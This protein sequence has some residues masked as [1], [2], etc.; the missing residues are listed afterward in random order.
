MCANTSRYVKAALFTFF[1]IRCR[2][3]A[4]LLTKQTL[5]MTTNNTTPNTSLIIQIAYPILSHISISYKDKDAQACNYVETQWRDKTAIK[6]TL[7]LYN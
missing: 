2:D 3:V 1:N 7:I 5:N 6:S 4:R